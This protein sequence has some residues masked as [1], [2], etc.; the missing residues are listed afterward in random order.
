MVNQMTVWFMQVNVLEE[1][2]MR[3]MSSESYFRPDVHGPMTHLAVHRKKWAAGRE[4]LVSI[5]HQFCDSGKIIHR[6]DYN[7]PLFY[8]K[9][10]YY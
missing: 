8:I 4:N 9:F 2:R 7:P 6:Y 10:Y 1:K 3:K 5:V